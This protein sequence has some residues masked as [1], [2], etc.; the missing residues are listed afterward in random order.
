MP[1]AQFKCHM[2]DNTFL[3]TDTVKW[4]VWLINGKK[5]VL[6]SLLVTSFS[7]LEINFLILFNLCETKIAPYK[8]RLPVICN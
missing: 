3:A 2:Q 1:E 5:K 8:I 7:D 4:G 6:L